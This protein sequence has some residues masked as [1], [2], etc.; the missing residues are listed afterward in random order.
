MYSTTEDLLQWVQEIT[1]HHKIIPAEFLSDIFQQSEVTSNDE[2]Y[3]NGL[4]LK[5]ANG[6]YYFGHDGFESGYNSFMSFSPE[7]RTAI[8]ILN[9]R[10]DIFTTPQLIKRIHS[11]INNSF[12]ETQF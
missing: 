1:I 4:F 3:A 7:N 9:N 8:I 5:K 2:F 10:V 12:Q 6:S 11:K